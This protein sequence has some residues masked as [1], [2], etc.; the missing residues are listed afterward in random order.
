MKGVDSA[1]YLGSRLNKR[2][3]IKEEITFQMQQVTITWT[4]LKTDWR[5][6]NASE[7]WLHDAIIKS[8]PLYGL[9]TAHVGRAELK[10]IDAFQI[11]GVRQILRKNH[12]YWDRTATNKSLFDIAS[13]ILSENTRETKGCPKKNKNSLKTCIGKDIRTVEDK[14]G[15]YCV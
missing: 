2:A 1:M 14:R 7:K 5:A 8:K 6:T 11:R 3:G 10:R 15:P 13:R 4:R 9:E 12:T